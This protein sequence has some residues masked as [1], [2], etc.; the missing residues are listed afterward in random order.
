MAFQPQSGTKIINYKG[1]KFD[2]K[3]ILSPQEQL[4]TTWEI[5]YI[6]NI[7]TFSVSITSTSYNIIEMTVNVSENAT[8]NEQTCSFYLVGDSARRLYY[9]FKVSRN[10]NL[11]LSPIYEDT[12][13]VLNNQTELDYSIVGS[14]SEMNGQVI[15]SGK[16][17]AMPNSN[18]IKVNINRVCSDYLSSKLNGYLGQYRYQYLYDYCKVFYVYS[19]GNEI[20]KYAF[21]NSY[22]Y[23][24]K[25]EI[26]LNEPIKGKTK[27][28]ETI[29]EVDKRQFLPISVYN[30]DSVTKRLYVN[31]YIDNQRAGT[32]SFYVNRDA[33]F[34]MF[35]R[36]LYNNKEQ[37]INK[38]EFKTPYI[39]DGVII[40]NI[41]ETCYDYCL[42]FVSSY[43]GWDYLLIKANSK[44][45]DKITSQYY[46]KNI[47]NKTQDFERVKYLNT[48]A[49]SYELHT[50]WFTDEEQSK[51]HNL[52][53][54]NE[55]YLHNLNTDEIL[56][57]NISNT[58]L[59]YKT[60]TNNGKKK[61]NNTINVEVAQEKIRK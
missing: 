5:E 46:T 53:E 44:K 41:V 47:D 61:F 15:Y 4:I 27:N 48:I 10:S 42:Y 12:Y 32:E 23:K 17:V 25:N 55:V 22:A 26:F 56:P 54:S 35:E 59:E 20:A 39:T 16:A 6:N 14:Y 58:T 1:G 57:V 9:E 2:L 36:E 11:V 51:L 37:P 45:N 52:I 38:I 19:N 8:H 29:I 60:F 33:Q 40:A 50:D 18:D 49:S 31:Y 21:Y 34:V 30:T 24:N 28:N 7:P 43:G 13:L 3:Y